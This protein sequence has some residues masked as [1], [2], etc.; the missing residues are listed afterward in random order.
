MTEFP[1][2]RTNTPELVEDVLKSTYF[3]LVGRE[4]EEGGFYPN[5]ATASSLDLMF[6]SREELIDFLKLSIALHIWLISQPEAEP[7]P[8]F[9]NR[10]LLS[11][12]RLTQLDQFAVFLRERYGSKIENVKSFS[13]EVYSNV[14]NVES[15]YWYLAAAWHMHGDKMDLSFVQPSLAWVLASSLMKRFK[16]L[17]KRNGCPVI[18]A[19][20]W[21]VYDGRKMEFED[22]WQLEIKACGS[23]KKREDILVERACAAFTTTRTDWAIKTSMINPFK[24]GGDNQ[25]YKNI[26]GLDM[27][28]LTVEDGDNLFEKDLALLSFAKKWLIEERGLTFKRPEGARIVTSDMSLPEDT[29]EPPAYNDDFKLLSDKKLAPFLQEILS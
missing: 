18:F 6:D 21:V 23:S 1:E 11:E 10:F 17:E 19:H 22:A 7:V 5:P 9:V 29:V 13:T 3:K 20:S 2:Q 25:K 26:A 16:G 15:D 24:D 27:D 4:P 12:K 28:L 14:I 8:F